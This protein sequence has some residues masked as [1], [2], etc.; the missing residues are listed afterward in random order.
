MISIG[1]VFADATQLYRLLWRRSVPIAAVVFAVIQVA[2][3][4][5]QRS[6]GGGPALAILVLEIVGAVFVQGMLVEAVRSVH[7][8]K[9]TPSLRGLYERIGS[10]FPTLM[11]G[12]LIYAFSVACGLL[13]FI[14]PGLILTARWCLFAPFVVLEGMSGREARARSWAVV[15]GHTG[16][17]LLVIIAVM[18]FVAVPGVLLQ[19]GF[20]SGSLAS[21]LLGFGWAVFAAPFEAHVLTTVYYRLTD[22]ERPLVHPSALAAGSV[23]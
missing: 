19:V 13:L 18:I 7:E 11:L 20:G 6:R 8:G 9:P 3:V 4:L 23:A 22:P 10:V 2:S 16:R 1:T 5:A 12:G 15:R 17:V 21:N 14:V